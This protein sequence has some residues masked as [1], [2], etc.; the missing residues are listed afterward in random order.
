[1]KFLK[2]HVSKK[3]VLVNME[4]VTEIHSKITG[5]CSLYFNTMVSD[6][7]QSYI[8]VDENMDKILELLAL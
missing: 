4:L 3:D 6:E 7:E 8:E 5:E 1:M 2:L